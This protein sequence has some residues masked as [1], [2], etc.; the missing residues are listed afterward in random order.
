MRAFHTLRTAVGNV[1]LC[2]FELLAMLLSALEWRRHNGNI[3]LVT[4]EAGMAYVHRQGIAAAWDRVVP[5]LRNMQQAGIDEQT[6]WAGA[7]LLALSQQ[8]A[9]C[10]MIDL[11]FIV[12]KKIDFER[13]QPAVVAIHRESVNNSV[14]PV[15]EFFQMRA[16]WQWPE[17]LDWSVEACNTAFVYFGSER[18][19]QVY[20]S[21][22][23]RFMRAADTR[24]A[25]LPYMVFAEQRLLAMCAVRL[26]ESVGTFADLPELFGGRQRCF[27]HL[28]GM[29]EHLRRNPEEAAAFCRSCVRRLQR[30]FPVFV[31]QVRTRAWMCRYL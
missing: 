7:K 4:D 21:L 13:L 28:W 5:G 10:I 17:S 9:P 20:C 26:R 18:L 6:F 19:R 12:W 30:D 24:N 25:G 31:R 14:Y 22:A 16:G 27:T 29:K 2:D 23:M 11:D 3:M 15:R 8:P 1:R